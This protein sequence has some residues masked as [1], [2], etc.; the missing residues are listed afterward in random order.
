MEIIRIIINML[1]E[2]G[3]VYGMMYVWNILKYLVTG[4]VHPTILGLIIS[5]V[6]GLWVA[7]AVIR[8]L[9]NR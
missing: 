5:V 3:A 6:M 8:W 2:A 9:D 1:I 7:K 4:K